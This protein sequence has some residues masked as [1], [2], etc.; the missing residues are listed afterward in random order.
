MS[1]HSGKVHHERDP[2]GS[3]KGGHLTGRCAELIEDHTYSKHT[4]NISRKSG[5]ASGHSEGCWEKEK[6]EGDRLRKAENVGHL[7]KKE[8]LLPMWGLEGRVS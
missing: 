7:Q 4:V 6:E 1:W 5:A 3:G 2:D 8:V